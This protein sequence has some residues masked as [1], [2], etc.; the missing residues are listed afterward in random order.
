MKKLNKNVA[1][2]NKGKLKPKLFGYAGIFIDG[3]RIAYAITLNN[4]KIVRYRLFSV[5]PGEVLVNE[6]GLHLHPSLSARVVNEAGLHL[7]P[8]LSARV[9]NVV[10]KELDSVARSSQLKIVGAGI[11]GDN[12]KII[13]RLCA[14]LWLKADIFPIKIWATR[15]G[16][17]RRSIVKEI[18]KETFSCFEYNENENVY[19]IVRIFL[20]HQ[21]GEIDPFYL[22]DRKTCQASVN[23]KEWKNLIRLANH[24]KGK[25]LVFVN[26]TPRGGGVAIMRHT[27]IH[28]YRLLGV[29]AHWYVMSPSP[30]IFQITKKK[31]H[32]VLQGISDERLT[33]DDKTN[34]EQWSAQNAKTLEE[35][36]KT[37]DVIVIDDYQPSG[38]IP[39]IKHI[40]PEI[41]IIYRS[42]IQLQ[43]NLI[44]RPDSV[45]HETWKFLWD[46]IKDHIDIFVSHPV[47]EFVPKDVP[48][49]KVVYIPAFTDPWDG[50]NKPLSKEQISFYIGIFNEL[51]DKKGQSSLDPKRPYIIQ[52]ARFDPAK[53]IPDVLQA[54]RL[55]RK[56]M[57]E[58]ETPLQ[59]TPQLVITGIGAID[60]PEGDKIFAETLEQINHQE[61]RKI[62]NDIKVLLAPPIDRILN[63]LLR[64][65]HIALQLSYAEGFE[66]KISEA[67]AKG[68]P[69][70]AYRTGG[71]PLQIKDKVNGFLVDV[72]NIEEVAKHLYTLL[73]N[74]SQYVKMSKNA[75]KF[76][77]RDVWTVGGA[78]K[79]L[80][81]VV[82]LT[83]KDVWT[84]SDTIKWLSLA[85][86]L[87]KK[88]V[89]RKI[90]RSDNFSPRK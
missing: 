84:V 12:P 10:I 18:T 16:I 59:N 62:R 24:F 37:T 85:L 78:A 71:I 49:E 30:H 44:A 51:L 23:K 64:Q 41:K 72:G 73:T 5:E 54:Y 19:P 88:Y 56:R 87:M 90:S 53:G 29:D 7:H 33:D 83:K 8:S 52:V 34:F 32:N 35:V 50:L 6:A 2:Q 70:I 69:V 81:L 75:R 38:M 79:W 40:N 65:S 67:L 74:K 31:I 36:F 61:F 89:N 42:H 28:F 80:S 9:S 57:Q 14:V 25:K 22:I 55:L 13:D 21:T 43:T 68:K 46:N 60:D 3:K 15:T 45:Q 66:V 27:L 1:L 17:T 58:K 76:V 82:K 77:R 48:S 4:K 20:N 39:H 47:P 11:A 26:S 63:A 86:K